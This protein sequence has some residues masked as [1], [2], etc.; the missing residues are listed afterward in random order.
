MCTHIGIHTCICSCMCTRAH[1]QSTQSPH[2]HIPARGGTQRAH[3]LT[4]TPGGMHGAHVL[5]HTRARTEPMRSRGGTHGAL[6][7]T[8]TR[9]PHMAGCFPPAGGSHPATLSARAPAA[10]TQKRGQL[11]RAPMLGDTYGISSPKPTAARLSEELAV[12]LETLTCG[13][14]P[15]VLLQLNGQCEGRPLDYVHHLWTQNCNPRGLCCR[16]QSTRV[17]VGGG[18]GTPGLHQH[19]TC[20]KQV[21]SPI[22]RAPG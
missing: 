1:T 12:F 14:F 13:H 8:C 4:H 18:V 15:I 21:L 6:V 9:R 16:E 19:P 11:G 3:V 2:A 7:L 5:I 22:P 10:R 20:P 17:C